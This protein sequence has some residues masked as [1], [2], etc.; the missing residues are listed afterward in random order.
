MKRILT[1]L[2]LLAAILAA[3][4]AATAREAIDRHERFRVTQ[5]HTVY[6][7]LATCRQTQVIKLNA[8]FVKY[9]REIRKRKVAEA[10]I[11]AAESG[12]RCPDTS[13]V[14]QKRKTGDVHPRFGCGGRC[15][16]NTTEAL[17]FHLGWPYVL[18]NGQPP[19]VHIAT[20]IRGRV[21]KRNGTVLGHICTQVDWIGTVGCASSE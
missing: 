18:N 1:T 21:T 4:Q 20:S 13:K 14:I 15:G 3:T 2:G 10:H 8:I 6:Y 11:R 5:T 12:R 17:G 16:R 9:R 7:S 19:F